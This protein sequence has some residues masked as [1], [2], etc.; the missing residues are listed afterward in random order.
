MPYYVEYTFLFHPRD[1]DDGEPSPSY[2]ILEF[3]SF[4]HANIAEDVRVQGLMSHGVSYAIDNFLEDLGGRGLIFEIIEPSR[5]I[6]FEDLPSSQ[7]KKEENE[8]KKE[9]MKYEPKIYG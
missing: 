7:N 8:K 5:V 2:I 4:V 3:P 6:S 9:E 1:D